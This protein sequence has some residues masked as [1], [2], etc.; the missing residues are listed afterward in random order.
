MTEQHRISDVLADESHPAHDATKSFVDDLKAGMI[1][2]CGCLGPMY[3]EPYCPCRM[4]Q[5]GLEHLMRE[6][7][8]RKA[9]EYDSEQQWKKFMEEGGF[10]RLFE[11]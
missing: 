11:D 10:S 8:L 1:N 6:N 7:P 4:K 9:A 3:G 5:E 2:L